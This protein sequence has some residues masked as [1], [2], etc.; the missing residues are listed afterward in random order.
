MATN[1]LEL[2]IT[3]KYLGAKWLPEEKV[4]FTRCQCKGIDVFIILGFHQSCDKTK[5]RNHSMN[6]VKILLF[7]IC[8][9][10][11]E[12]SPNFI[13]LCMEMPCLFLSEGHKYGGC[14]VTQ[15]SVTQFCY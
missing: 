15:T 9:L 6:K 4:N 3:L 14:K 13:E 5:N 10:F 12:V 8:T 7:F 2:A 1:F 11:A